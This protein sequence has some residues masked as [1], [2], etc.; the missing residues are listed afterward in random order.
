[1]GTTK[2]IIA[3]QIKLNLGKR[4]K[5]SEPDIRELMLAVSQG[6]AVSVFE[7]YSLSRQDDYLHIPEGLIYRFSGVEVEKDGDTDE[8][9]SQLPGQLLGL[10]RGIGIRGVSPLKSQHHSYDP[11]PNGFRDIYSGLDSFDN[12]G[13]IGYMI[14]NNRIIYH[15]MDGENNPEK[16]VVKMV[17]PINSIG[18]DD[19][20]NISPE[21]EA[22]AVSYAMNLYGQTSQIPQDKSNDNVDQ[23]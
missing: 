4:D 1:M 3:E 22:K 17:A 18:D 13:K 12:E 8:Y 10:Y 15:N 11:L 9:Y 7:H 16:V 21:M 23:I 2:R 6:I 5:Q 20:I 19:V 14:E